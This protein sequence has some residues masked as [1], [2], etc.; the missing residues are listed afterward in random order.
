MGLV[1]VQKEAVLAARRSIVTVEKIV[2]ELEPR[3]NAVVLPS[4][5]VS[6]VCLVPGGA[7][8]SFAMGFS[9]RDNSFYRAWDEISR[10]RDRS[11][12]GSTST[13]VAP[14]TSR[15]TAAAPAS[16]TEPRGV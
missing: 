1:G 9:E 13:C 14:P 15:S 8:P 2:D 3:P 16:S 10:D 6:S 12:P 11:R 7:H 5:V 4:W